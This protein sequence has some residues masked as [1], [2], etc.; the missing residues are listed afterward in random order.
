MRR[1]IGPIIGARRTVSRFIQRSTGRRKNGDCFLSLADPGQ[2]KSNSPELP[3]QSS[4]FT[5]Q[6]TPV[7]CAQTRKSRRLSMRIHRRVLL[8]TLSLLAVFL[9]LLVGPAT[10]GADNRT[11]PDVKRVPKVA[12]IVTAY[13]HN[14]HADVIVSRLLQTMTLDDKGERPA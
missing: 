7:P 12:A 5:F 6:T 2:T 13:F 4:E 8:A 9:S 1:F 14:S 11:A 10:R 3:C